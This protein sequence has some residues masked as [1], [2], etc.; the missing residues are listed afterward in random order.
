MAEG[1]KKFETRSWETRYR[2]LLAIHAAA[3]P[4]GAEDK[5]LLEKY[6]IEEAP[7]SC[8]LAVVQLVDCI[9]MTEEFIAEQSAQ[10]IEWGDWRPGRWAWKFENLMK[11]E[12]PIPAKGY[13]QIWNI[14]DAEIYFEK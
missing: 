5:A 9:P 6:G 7:L 4:V 1:F 8:F 10:E 3:L 14:T 11:L 13:Q 12:T 2:G